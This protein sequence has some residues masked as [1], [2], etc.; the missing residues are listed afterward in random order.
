M[1]VTILL[2]TCVLPWAKAFRPYI[3][4]VGCVYLPPI[5]GTGGASSYPAK[6]SAQSSPSIAAETMPPA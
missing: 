3:A 4:T 1:L 2:L 5:G 6:C